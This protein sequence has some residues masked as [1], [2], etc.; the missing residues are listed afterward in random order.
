MATYRT[1]LH[2]IPLENSNTVNN[3]QPSSVLDHRLYS[4]SKSN[5]SSQLGHKKSI[6]FCGQQVV[7]YIKLFGDNNYCGIK[8]SNMSPSK[9]YKNRDTHQMAAFGWTYPTIWFSWPS[10]KFNEL[11]F[12]TDRLR[13]NHKVWKFHFVHG[14]LRVS[15]WNNS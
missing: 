1:I 7:Q 3:Y 15:I 11:Y 5:V 4:V 13:F 2:N 8:K 14:S 9:L 10:K 6:I 12:S